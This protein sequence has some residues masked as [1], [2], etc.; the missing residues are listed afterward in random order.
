MDSPNNNSHDM[1]IEEDEPEL[2]DPNLTIIN[3]DE[4]PSPLYIYEVKFDELTRLLTENDID[5]NSFYLNIIKIEDDER[6][7]NEL[8]SRVTISL[9]VNNILNYKK[10]IQILNDKQIL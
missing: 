9:H 4:K 8:E 7:T 5:P 3:K 1:N 10:I 6:P 2:A